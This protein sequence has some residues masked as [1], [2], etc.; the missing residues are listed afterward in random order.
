M[1]RGRHGVKEAWAM[2]TNVSC[3]LRKLLPSQGNRYALTL[4]CM[5]V[6]PSRSVGSLEME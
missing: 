4:K 5:V 1:C 6:P 3:R 2:G